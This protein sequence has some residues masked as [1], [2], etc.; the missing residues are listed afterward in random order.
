LADA[1]FA[2]V[3]RAIVQVRRQTPDLAWMLDI[4]GV[5][6]LLVRR[7]AGRIDDQ[8][9]QYRLY[10]TH[11]WRTTSDA[12]RQWRAMVSIDPA[13][14]G[15][16]RQEMRRRVEQMVGELGVQLP[17]RRGQFW[18]TGG[19]V[20]ARIADLALNF[21]WNEDQ[22]THYLLS[23]ATWGQEGRNATGGIAAAM[24]QFRQIEEQY[25]VQSTDRQRF[26][27]ARRVLMGDETIE[28]VEQRLRTRALARWGDN[29][30]IRGVLER[31]GTV[32]DVFEDYRQLASQELER[33]AAE[34]SMNQ[35]RWQRM[36]EGEDGTR[37]MSM[38]EALRYIRS[39]AEWATTRGAR[40]QEA[41]TVNM[42]LSTFGQRA[43]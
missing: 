25:G 6:D 24:T 10:R 16:Q 32:A 22:L 37:P 38:D 9:F 17:R 39:Q 5:G 35:T 13:Q 29:D 12:T 41:S 19:T 2:D 33:P 20:T 40:Q 31:G 30:R 4:P 18:A 34:F 11:W 1:T 26:G 23:H 7:A 21:G 3:L 14:A 27:Q 15:R 36:L 43:A 42:L 28:G 8:E